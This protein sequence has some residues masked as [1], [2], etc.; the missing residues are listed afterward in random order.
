MRGQLFPGNVAPVDF[1]AAGPMARSAEDLALAL[2][3]MAGPDRLEAAGWR[4][5]L[6]PYRERPLSDFKV[7]IIYDNANSRVDQEVQDR[8]QGLARFLAQRG[9]TVSETARPDIDFDE[10]HAIYIKLLRAATSSAQSDE[11]FR[12]NFAFA[13]TLNAE[14]RSYHARMMRAFTMFHRDW[15]AADEVRHRMRYKWAAFFDDY[16]LLLCPAAASA[17]CPHDHVGERYQRTIAVNGQRVPATDQLFWAGISTVVD[18]PATVAPIGL[19]P[20]GLPVGVQI[21]GAGYADYTCIGF[22]GLLEREYYAF[23]PPPA[24]A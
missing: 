9:A 22:A 19:T 15:L 14:D 11:T 18:L 1:F 24:F 6:P 4:L 21:I 20:G 17:A 7:A 5:A 3:I 12:S 16:D 13:Q 10:A 8:L 2:T 23:A